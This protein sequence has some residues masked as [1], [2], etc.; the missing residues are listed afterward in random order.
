MLQQ[1]LTTAMIQFENIS[2]ITDCFRQTKLALLFEL[3]CS[4]YIYHHQKFRSADQY[5]E[6][7]WPN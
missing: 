3:K 7:C 1:F 5:V 2:K 6:S 4:G